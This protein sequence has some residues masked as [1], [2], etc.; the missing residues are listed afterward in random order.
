MTPFT[1]PCAQVPH[2]HYFL[3]A[4]SKR[5]VNK[6][7]TPFLSPEACQTVLLYCWNYFVNDSWG[8]I[9]FG[10][11]NE[12]ANHYHSVVDDNETVEY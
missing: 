7:A 2:L 3:A 10:K 6:R 9:L 12:N 1:T 5:P 11:L 4:F 8:M